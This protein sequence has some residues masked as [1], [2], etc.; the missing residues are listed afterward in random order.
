[1]K[2]LHSIAF[3]LVIIGGLNWGLSGLGD[4]LGQDLNVVH[5]ILSF[6]PQLES[7]VYVLVGVSAIILV[8]SHKKD[9]RY[10]GVSGG[11]V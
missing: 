10:C 8:T 9:C 11:A 5:L 7:L 4:F 6:Y 1:M 3:I 2:G